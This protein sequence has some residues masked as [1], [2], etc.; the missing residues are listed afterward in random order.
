MILLAAMLLV[1][2][3][4]EIARWEK[5]YSARWRLKIISSKGLDFTEGSH[6]K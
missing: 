6:T 3:E 5:N 2:P 4:K 1:S